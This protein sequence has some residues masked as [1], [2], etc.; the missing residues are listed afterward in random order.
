MPSKKTTNPKKLS[1]PRYKIG[2]LIFGKHHAK[3]YNDIYMTVGYI[4][5]NDNKTDWVY[6]ASVINPVLFSALLLESRV[7]GCCNNLAEYPACS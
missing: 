1:P 7:E 3:P 5:S 2:D 4:V 6:Y